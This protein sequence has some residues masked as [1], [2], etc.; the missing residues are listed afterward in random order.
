MAKVAPENVIE[1]YA[2]FYFPA[3]AF[4]FLDVYV[5][6]QG[7]CLQSNGKNLLQ[8]L[9]FFQNFKSLYFYIRQA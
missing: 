1:N 8:I 7:Y 3:C 2:D 9:M 6:Q 5:F 4:P